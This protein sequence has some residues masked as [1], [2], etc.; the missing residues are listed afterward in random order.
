MIL[1]ITVPSPKLG[2]T[3]YADL[4][5]DLRA[6]QEIMSV[7]GFVSNLRS[8]LAADGLEQLLAELA[9]VY[10]AIVSYCPAEVVSKIARDALDARER[11]EA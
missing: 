9:A 2:D 1:P 6:D 8:G 11:K 5:R 10:E 7:G 3:E 4:I